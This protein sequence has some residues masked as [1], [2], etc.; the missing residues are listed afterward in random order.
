MRLRLTSR[1]P[2]I[3]SDP[4]GGPVARAAPWL[5]CGGLRGVVACQ[6]P[7]HCPRAQRAP[8][9][10]LGVAAAAPVARDRGVRVVEGLNDHGVLLW[11]GGPPC[12]GLPPTSPALAPRWPC[13]RRTVAAATARQAR[14]AAAWAPTATW[15]GACPGPP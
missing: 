15:V 1:V 13:G 2:R 14:S 3:G 5:P 6:P 10:G 7:Q 4:R 12:G 8:V 9:A 11:S